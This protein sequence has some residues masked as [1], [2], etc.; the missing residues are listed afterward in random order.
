M[1]EFDREI[2]QEKASYTSTHPQIPRQKSISTTSLLVF[3]MSPSTLNEPPCPSI[4]CSKDGPSQGV[5]SVSTLHNSFDW[6][7]M[8]DKAPTLCTLLED[9]LTQDRN[10]S[11]TS[12]MNCIPKEKLEKTRQCILDVVSGGEEEED[13]SESNRTHQRDTFISFGAACLQAFVQEAFTGPEWM[14]GESCPE[15]IRALLVWSE[16]SVAECTFGHPFFFVDMFMNSPGIPFMLPLLEFQFQNQ[17]NL[18]HGWGGS[19]LFVASVSI[20]AARSTCLTPLGLDHTR[21]LHN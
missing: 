5:K 14:K 9:L 8:V 15:A 11:D 7:C 12:A 17:G 4:S 6:S 18:G 21:P 13:A 3:D 16:V 2:T 20:F 10:T 1:G 19:V